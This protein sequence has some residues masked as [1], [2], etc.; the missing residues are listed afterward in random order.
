MPEAFSYGSGAEL[1][2][3]RFA[4]VLWEF[5]MT[6]NVTSAP[7]TPSTNGLAEQGFATST[8]DVRAAL[9][10]ADLP[11]GQWNMALRWAVHVRN[12]LAT[13]PRVDATTGKTEWVTPFELFY[14]RKPKMK[15]MC[16]FGAPCR[17]LLLNDQRPA[18]KFSQHTARGKIL[19]RGEDGVQMAFTDR[20]VL[21]W[22]VRLDD[23][24][25]MHSRHVEIDE[26]SAVR[27]PLKGGYALTPVSYDGALPAD[28]ADDTNAAAEIEIIS[29]AARGPIAQQPLLERIDARHQLPGVSPDDD[30]QLP[31]GSPEDDD[32]LPGGSPDHLSHPNPRGPRQGIATQGGTGRARPLP[33]SSRAAA[34]RGRSLTTDRGSGLITGAPAQQLDTSHHRNREDRVSR[35]Q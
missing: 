22:V 9:A 28:S 27:R 23:G 10:I 26:R 25:I 18:G 19:G 17:V 1:N 35:S 32:Q 12:K 8:P 14:R 24:R 16:A 30:D 33:S 7:Q 29:A 5:G 20:F 15:H 11:H 2:S 31:G 3:R 4:D 34:S 13:R 21:G 6:G